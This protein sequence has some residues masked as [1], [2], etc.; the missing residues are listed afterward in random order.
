MTH[1]FRLA[2]LIPALAVLTIV[3]FAGGIGVI[4]MVLE[5]SFGEWGVLGLGVGLTVGVPSIAAL[6]ESRIKSV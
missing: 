3:V 4:F 6:L 1:Q 2:L 5:S